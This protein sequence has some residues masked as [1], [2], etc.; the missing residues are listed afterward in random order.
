MQEIQQLKAS[1]GPKARLQL[2]F[3]FVV[4]SL[5]LSNE[6]FADSCEVQRESATISCDFSALGQ[7]TCFQSVQQRDEVGCPTGERRTE[8]RSGL[9]RVRS[10][11][12]QHRQLRRADIE[13]SHEGGEV[14]IGGQLSPAQR[15]RETA[16]QCLSVDLRP[17]CCQSRRFGWVISFSQRHTLMSPNADI[18]RIPTGCGASFV[19]QA[20]NP[21]GSSSFAQIKTYR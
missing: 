4:G 16:V 14:L 6:G 15:V 3:H 8:C 10:N 13:V 1:L 2:L 5:K 11:Q 21:E 17:G 20:N 19:L 9:A 18:Q 12:H 7:I